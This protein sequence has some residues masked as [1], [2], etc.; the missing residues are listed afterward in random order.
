M[1]TYF[2]KRVR[3]VVGVAG[4]EGVELTGLR[5]AF[6]VRKQDLS[7]PNT[8]EVSVWGLDQETRELTRIPNTLVQIFA[9]YGDLAP[10]I[11]LGAVTRSETQRDGVEVVTKLESGKPTPAVSPLGKTFSGQQVLKDM[12]GE[13]AG[14]L[15]AIGLDL[16]KVPDTPINAPRGVT[17]SGDPYKVLNRLTRANN[18][19]WTIEDGIVRVLPR[20]QGTSQTAVLLT[21]R[22]GLV[23]S[24]RPVQMQAGGQAA[25]AAVEIKSL[26]NGELNIR[27]VV[28]LA[29]V[30]EMAGW[31]LIRSVSHDGDTHGTSPMT[32]TLEATPIEATP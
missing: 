7:S 17:L 1:T 27:R 23:G 21:P 19:D 29:E 32:T 30:D 3:V 10:L 22:T 6:K 24:P 26:L 12:L 18:L 5:V 14:G 15:Q 25:R 16:D 20:G 13:A 9:G 28:S 31:Y 2:N 4:Q 11:F 8:A